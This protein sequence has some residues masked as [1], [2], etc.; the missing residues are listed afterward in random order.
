MKLFCFYTR[1]IQFEP[2]YDYNEIAMS[3]V[4]TAVFKSTIGLLVNKGRD[5]AAERLKEGDVTDQKFRGVIMREIDNVKLKLDGLAR[6]DLLASI[7]FF[8]EGIE[9]L[10]VVF[11]RVARSGSQL[12]A[13]KVPDKSAGSGTSVSLVKEIEKLRL[14]GLDDSATRALVNTKERFK[15]ARRKATEAF[16]NQA[17]ELSDRLLAMQYRVMATVLETIDNPEDALASCRVSLE[18]LHSLSAVQ[19]CFNVELKK[20]LRASLSK[21]E[22]RQIIST[23]CQ[24]NRVIYDVTLMVTSRGEVLELPLLHAGKEKVDPSRDRRIAKALRK[25]GMEHCCIQWSFGQEGDEEHKLK[26]P[27]GI[28]T[29]T[30]GELV[31]ADNGDKT[32]KVFNSSGSYCHSFHL[33]T[34]DTIQLD[35]RDVAADVENNTYVLVRLKRSR[36]EK[37]DEYEREVWVFQDGS[38][39]PQRK[40]AVR[41]GDQGWGKLAVCSRHVLVLRKSDSAVVDVYDL[42]GKFVRSLGDWMFMYATDITAAH[43]DRVMV[44]DRGKSCVRCFNTEGQELFNFY[45]NIEADYY[46][47][48]SCHLAGELVVVAG[49]ERETGHPVVAVFTKA[50]DLIRK[51]Q[52]DENKVRWFGGVAVS[53]EGLVAAAVVVRSDCKV[54]V[55]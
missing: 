9:S 36:A 42:D 25:V 28:A 37:R 16:A 32:V 34:D 35:I 50:G 1:Q 6:K 31:I 23:V 10:F 29:N 46:Y 11:D 53:M 38:A 43:N 8:K 33:Q 52:L 39:D 22:R 12:S 40:F 44:V 13:I 14:T 7:S 2:F 47:R 27:Q 4:V 21:E 51:I 49:H 20:G 5:K 19:T 48:V 17:L 54:I 18:E 3:L 30:R 55:V 41:K 45:I 26:I 24:V 15:D